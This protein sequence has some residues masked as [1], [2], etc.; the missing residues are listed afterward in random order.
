MKIYIAQAIQ[1][2]NGPGSSQD[3]SV[4]CFSS[5]EKRLKFINDWIA[6]NEKC[7]H[8][9]LDDELKFFSSNWVYWIETIEQEIDCTYFMGEIS[10][11]Y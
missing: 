7:K 8:D 2:Q 5:G 10:K 4:F 11:R 6:K 1:E 3:I 9:R